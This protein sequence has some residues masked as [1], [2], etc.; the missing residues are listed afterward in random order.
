MTKNSS[1]DH[2][3]RRNPRLGNDSCRFWNRILKSA[4]LPGEEVNIFCSDLSKSTFPH[5]KGFSVP[6]AVPPGMRTRIQFRM[7]F[8]RLLQPRDK[9]LIYLA[10]QVGLVPPQCLYKGNNTLDT[11]VV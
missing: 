10:P 1:S 9:V 11:H 3:T 2:F 6:V 7:G 4:E 5:G 8:W